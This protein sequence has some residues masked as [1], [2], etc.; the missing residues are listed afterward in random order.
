MFED[1]LDFSEG[2]AKIKSNNKWSYI[3][4]IGEIIIAPQFSKVDD[5]KENLAPV[6]KW[7]IWGYVNRSGK[8]VIPFQYNEVNKFTGRLAR[9]NFNFHWVYINQTGVIIASD[10]LDYRINLTFFPLNWLNMGNKILYKSEVIF[11]I[12]AFILYKCVIIPWSYVVE[13]VKVPFRD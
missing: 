7:N 1:A 4:H 10:K 9:V 13:K 12:M 2:L 5:F 3:N 8:I 6:R 11:G